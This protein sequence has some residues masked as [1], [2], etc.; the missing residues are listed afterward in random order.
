MHF[1]EYTMERLVKE[2]HAELLEAARLEALLRQAPSRSSALRLALGT[3]HLRLG[4]WLL[5][6]SYSPV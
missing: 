6:R 2:R 1:N 3:A 4:A 5:R